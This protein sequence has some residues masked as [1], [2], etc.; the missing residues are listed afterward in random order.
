M[1]STV[2]LAAHQVRYEQRA[3]WRNRRAALFGFALPVLVLLVFGALM[4]G[5]DIDTRGHIDVLTYF[6]PGIMA[7]GIMTT[8]FMSPAMGLATQRDKGVLK[9]MR[10]TPLPWSAYVTGR[11]ASTAINAVTVVVLVA[12][13]GRVAF[14]VGL[15]AEALP[16][17][18][19]TALLG[20]TAFTMLG[21]GVVR[22]VPNA[23]SVGPIIGLGL[24][25]LSFVSG[26]FS[27]LDDAPQWLRT[28]GDVL[29]LKPL[30]DALQHAF[31]PR[32]SGMA[33]D[34]GDLLCLAIWTAIGAFLMMQ[35]LRTA[36][37]KT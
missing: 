16:A 3:F 19:V 37:S 32:G 12:L 22:F 25:V 5:D 29:P 1:S 11:V 18:I 33:F 8:A 23:E 10:G 31:D 7:Y 2:S 36:T 9:R 34:G 4:D 30:A 27:P 21:I 14:G 20:I 35:F 6:V 15:R 26:L 13:L 24:W 28:T 17:V